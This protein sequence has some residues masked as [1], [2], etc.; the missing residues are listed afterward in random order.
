MDIS[1]QILF[2][3]VLIPF[4]CQIKFMINLGEKVMNFF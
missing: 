4:R 2:V 1:K 3:G